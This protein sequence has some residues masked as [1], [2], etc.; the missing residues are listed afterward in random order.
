[1]ET[2]DIKS[3]YTLKYTLHIPKY[4]HFK[5]ELLW[6]SFTYTCLQIIISCSPDRN[7]V[8][9]NAMVNLE[10]YPL[11]QI[12]RRINSKYIF[13]DELLKRMSLN[14]IQW[15]GRKIHYTSAITSVVVCWSRATAVGLSIPSSLINFSNLEQVK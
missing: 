10:S 7:K 11:K 2:G 14:G 4:L 3:N 13:N 5:I 6:K 15:S 9:R 1:M 12:F 8:K